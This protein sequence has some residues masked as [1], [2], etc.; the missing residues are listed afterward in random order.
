MEDDMRDDEARRQL[1]DIEKRL[2]RIERAVGLLER[3]A[4]KPMPAASTGQFC[5]CGRE[6]CRAPAC[7]TFQPDPLGR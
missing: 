7:P 2:T 6:V 4:E 3:A 5:L 1:D